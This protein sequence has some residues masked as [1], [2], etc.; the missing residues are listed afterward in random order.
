MKRFALALA[1]PLLVYLSACTRDPKEIARK[2][3]ATGNKY[4]E[5]GKYKE[6]SIMYRRALQKNMRDAQAHYRL[7]LIELKQGMMGEARRSFLRAT[8]IDHNN[9]D[10]LAKLGDINMAI[11]SFDP[12]T[13]KSYLVDAK[14]VTKRL[15]DKD[16]RSY[17]GLRLSGYIAF[18]EKD[19]PGA[20]QKLRS[21]NSVKPDQP[22]LALVLAKALYANKEP[23]QAERTVKDIISK[24][25][26]FEPAYDLL[27]AHYAAANRIDDAE[28]ISKQKATN[29]PTNANNWIQLAFH[30]FLTKRP[31]DMNAALARLTSDPKTFPQGHMVAG[32]FLMRIGAVDRA[33]HEYQAGEKVDPK[34]KLAYGKHQAEALAAEGKSSEAATLISRLFKDNPKDTETVAMH[35]SVLTQSKD[36]KQIQK[37]IDELQPMIASTPA[38]QPGAL[39]I[40]H[41]NLARAYLAKGDSV[42]A[43]KAREHFEATV[44]LNPNHAPA[45]LALSEM[46]IGRGDSAKAVQTVDEVIK[47]QPNNLR[48]R[49]VRTLGLISMGETQTARQELGQ[50]LQ[51]LPKSNDA[52]FQLA[53]LDLQEKRYKE[54]EANFEILFKANDPR[55]VTGLVRCKA[56]EGD[57]NGAI[58]M[59]RDQVRQSPGNEDY[60]RLLVDAEVRAGRIDDAIAD[61]QPILQKAPTSANY[62]HLGELQRI[63]KQYDAA[64]VNYKKAEQLYP[65]QALPVLGLALVYD[66]AGRPEQARQEYEQVL[67]LE[68]DNGIA[69]NNLAYSMADQ[70]VDLDKALAYAERARAK[71]PDNLDISD[72]LGLIYLRK[73]QIQ[74]S[75]R[76]LGELVSKVPNRAT[77]HLH[78]ATALYQKGDKSA[79]RKELDAAVRTGPTEKE[80]LQIEELRQKL[81]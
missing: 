53:S 8:D 1:I 13:Y 69:L 56:Q 3:V 35:A 75:T 23:E 32:D 67:K 10:A 42:S 63:S 40:L 54:A 15:L 33:L 43:E 14:E 12:I 64:I 57:M 68:P 28:S 46:M 21:A 81:S 80:K 16:A 73:N 44:K 27:Y 55:G 59:A 48:A 7:G 41:F 70:G 19:L 22:D 39:Q 71:M 30:Y 37:A 17:D 49:L 5:K 4:Y 60:R 20:I 29:N 58:Q 47:A 50:I 6:A 62:V 9:V 78:Y 31:D 66:F 11:Y 25:K 45:K 34:N 74:E 51:V 24:H 65:N 38:S 61:F 52:R 72:T 76:L 77:Y 18:A 2:Y 36:P 26:E 79:A